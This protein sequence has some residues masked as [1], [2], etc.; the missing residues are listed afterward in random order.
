MTS[1]YNV[2]GT[3]DRTGSKDNY[4]I[5]VNEANKQK[6]GKFAVVE[7]KHKNYEVPLRAYGRVLVNNSLADHEVM[8]DQTLR[9]AVAISYNNDEFTGFQEKVRLYPLKIS[10]RKRIFNFIAS[11]FAI[12][13][14]YC[15]YNIPNI[16]D[17][18]KELIRISED[19]FDLLGCQNSDNVICEFPFQNE[20]GE[21]VLNTYKVQAYTAS[22]KMIDERKRIEN[23]INDPNNIRYRSVLQIL[24]LD[25]DIPRIFIDYHIRESLG[26]KELQP[27]AVRR[28][29]K[30][31]FL[32]QIMHFG[33]VLMLTLITM[34]SVIPGENTWIK[35]LYTSLVSIVFSIVLV[36]LNIRSTLK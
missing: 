22:G 33:L 35:L 17:V 18:E 20:D 16:I 23:D 1:Y 8:L 24:E 26:T 15:R 2:K 7:H 11:K 36:L 32:Q 6:L 14:I 34:A 9:I 10:L 28:D 5:C 27:I 3:E 29:V 30:G 21:F 19:T 4:I 12:R 25:P 31:L 13:Y